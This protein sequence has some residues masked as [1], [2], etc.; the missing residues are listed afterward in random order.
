MTLLDRE[1]HT[2]QSTFARCPFLFTVGRYKHQVNRKPELTHMHRSLRHLFPILQGQVGDLPHRHALRST[3]RCRRPAKWLEIGRACP[4]IYPP[5]HVCRPCAEMGRR[6]KL[7]VHRS[8]DSVSS[9]GHSRFW[10]SQYGYRIATDLNLH[11]LS[12]VKP[13]NDQHRREILNQERLWLIC[14]NLDRS[15]ATQFG[16]PS[17]IRED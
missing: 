6:Q 15:M 12:T 7:A 13:R 9:E 8:G 5:Q 2:V 1:I 17:T 10:R 14:H 4:G 3:R 11:Q 16:K